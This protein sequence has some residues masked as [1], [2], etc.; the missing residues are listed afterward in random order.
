MKILFIR[1]TITSNMYHTLLSKYQ[2]ISIIGDQIDDPLYH[3]AKQEL[4]LIRVILQDPS[5]FIILLQVL[6]FRNN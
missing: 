1:D 6:L 5:R 3:N 4:N 2:K